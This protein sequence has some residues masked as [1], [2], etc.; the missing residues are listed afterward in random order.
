[1]LM[2]GDSVLG[3]GFER[4]T[5]V[6]ELDITTAT[7]EYPRF[8]LFII[9]SQGASAGRDRLRDNRATLQDVPGLIGSFLNFREY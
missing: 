7:A 2:N 6:E 4:V 3:S 8:V 5:L 9:A 1:M